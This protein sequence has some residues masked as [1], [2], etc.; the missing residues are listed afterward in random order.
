MSSISE[1]RRWLNSLGPSQGLVR[2]AAVV[3]AVFLCGFAALG[4]YHLFYS[5][6][7]LPGTSVMGADLGGLTP[8]QGIARVRSQFSRYDQ[9]PLTLVYGQQ[10]WARTPRELGLRLDAKGTVQAAIEAGRGDTPW[11]LLVGPI[12]LLRSEESLPPAV[13]VDTTQLQNT[14]NEIASEVNREPVDA[15]LVIGGDGSVEISPSRVGLMLD[16]TQTSRTIEGRLLALSDEPI[17]LVVRELPPAVVEKQLEP[18]L[19]SAKAVLSAPIELSF[20]DRVWTL[21]PP[22]I[23]SLLKPSLANEGA[24]ASVGIVF[25]EAK[26]KELLTTIAR[27]VDVAPVDAT[28]AYTDGN[29]AMTDHRDG[30]Q[31]DL[32]GTLEELNRGIAQHQG[33]VALKVNTVPAQV[34][35]EDLVPIKEQAEKVLSGPITVSFE[36]KTWEVSQALLA[37]SLKLSKETRSGKT[38]PRVELDE[39][40]LASFVQG[41]AP[42]VAR[43]PKDARFQFSDGV[44][45]VATE[46]VDGISLDVPATVQAIIKAATTDQRLVP[47]AVRVEHPQ[48]Q[49]S[50]ASKIV[51]RDRLA[52]N[53]SDYTGGAAERR[54][55]IVLA[56][57]RLDGIVVPPGG[58]F[59]FN[60]AIG[61]QT[62]DNGYQNGYGITI[63]DGK[64]HTVPTVAG[65]IC[66]VATTLFQ[67]VFYAGLPIVERHPHYYWIPRYAQ[68]TLGMRGLD[69]TVDDAY[70]VDFRFR[71]NT[72]N[73]IA[74]KTGSDD[75][76]IYMSLYGIDPGWKVEIDD[77]VITNVV[78]PDTKLVESIEPSFPPG[79]RVQVETPVE[80]FDAV[81]TRRVLKGG[82]VI[83]ETVISSH[84]V[85]QRNEV[86]VGPTPEGQCGSA[87]AGTPT[88]AGGCGTPTP[89]ST[90][91]PAGTPPSAD[92]TPAGAPP[93]TESPAAAPTQNSPTPTGPSPAPTAEPSPT[94]SP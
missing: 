6:R 52:T 13:G 50:D 40:P 15:H 14:L 27:E 51:I 64:P 37:Q 90:P 54:H 49:S 88:P 75:T 9:A 78:P 24:A 66:Q 76:Y 41:I 16:V 29:L 61:P 32:S 89:G 10:S 46:S 57:S 19:Q 58:E 48:V 86:L 45:T 39:A 60:A 22:Q 82:Q 17:P 62:T 83:D 71:N 31:V 72:G 36:D 91:N 79:K 34:R 84:Y 21:D 30:R 25:D 42:E 70:G 77:P 5:G 67:T 20:E 87:G 23:A 68:T 56:T 12:Q 1:G 35:S 74:I 85:P 26:T 81:I 94:S 28:L 2:V 69:T 53:R 3:A 4:F 73:W 18:A 44:V 7:I 59:S 92:G 93:A 63:Q 11:D 33:R 65:G 8:E 80:G 38:L 43:E 47:L 55:N